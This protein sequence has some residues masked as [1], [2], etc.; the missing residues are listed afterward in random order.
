MITA[1]RPRKEYREP[2]TCQPAADGDD[3]DAPIASGIQPVFIASL[4]GSAGIE[5]L[6]SPS[7]APTVTDYKEGGGNAR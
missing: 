5:I 7:D 6:V 4:L 3:E 1:P 2:D